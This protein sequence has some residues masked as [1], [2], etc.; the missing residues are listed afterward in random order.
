MLL[1][2]RCCSIQLA[3]SHLVEWLLCND[4]CCFGSGWSRSGVRFIQIDSTKCALEARVVT[5]VALIQT[6][7][8]GYVDDSIVF[9]VVNTLNTQ[10]LEEQRLGLLEDLLQFKN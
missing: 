8:E 6:S 9:L 5:V 10:R 3:C 7:V 1:L 2:L 4:S